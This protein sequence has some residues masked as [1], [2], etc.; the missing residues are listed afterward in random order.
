[1]PLF[2][3]SPRSTVF[4]FMHFVALP[5]FVLLVSAPSLAAQTPPKPVVFAVV[6]STVA[7]TGLNAPAAVAVDTA[8]NL[9][10]A[11]TGN[12]RVV[13]VTPAGAQSTMHSGT[14]LVKA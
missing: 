7:T 5:L 6:Q 14:A 8:G 3:P 4:V 13:R 2:R 10:I 11:D 12:N 1:M 9:Y